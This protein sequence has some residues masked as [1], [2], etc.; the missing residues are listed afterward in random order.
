MTPQ[1]ILDLLAVLKQIKEKG[2]Q[3]DIHRSVYIVGGAFFLCLFLF[4]I[5]KVFFKN[6]L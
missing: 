5:L 1:G 3:W 2:F 6:K 4:P